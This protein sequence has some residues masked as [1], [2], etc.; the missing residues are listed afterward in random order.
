SLARDAGIFFALC[1]L[2]IMV[3]EW[4]KLMLFLCSNSGRNRVEGQ[5]VEETI[6]NE[7]S[8]QFP[9]V[10]LESCVINSLPVSQFKKDEVEGEHMPVNADCAICLGEF[11]EGEWLK[12]L[13]NCTHG[14]HASCIDT[15]FRSHSNCPLCRAY[16]SHADT[17]EC[18]VSLYTLLETSR[19]QDFSTE[20]TA[21]FQSPENL[22]ITHHS[23]PD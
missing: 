20:T 1:M 10:N 16:V 8:I 4:K 3:S 18:S 15:W 21:Y 5:F 9:S 13:P 14:F 11:E 22:E 2:F 7:Y 23:C 19:S 17:Q 6:P 12:L